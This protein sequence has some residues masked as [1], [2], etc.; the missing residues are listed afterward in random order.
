MAT[1][2]DHPTAVAQGEEIGT[3]SEFMRLLG[4]HFDEL[5]PTRVTGWLDTG[6]QH[7]QPFG[8]L[9]GGVLSSVVETF[10]STGAWHAVH[11][12]GLHPVG[13]SN[14]TDFIRSGTGGRLDVVGEAIHQGATNQLW[15]VTIRRHG[16]GELVAKGR[17]RLQHITP[18]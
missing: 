13:V 6:P 15:E 18:R 3:S 5:G 10:A 9:H 2:S 17:V 8:L 16:D 12:R 1:P 11:Q 7:H 14:S 4:C